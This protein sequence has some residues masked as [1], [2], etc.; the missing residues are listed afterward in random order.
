[1]AMR[2]QWCGPIRC[3]LRAGLDLASP[4]PT[5]GVVGFTAGDLRR[6][7]QEGVPDW[8]KGDKP[9]TTQV[10]DSVVPGV[11]LRTK[12]QKRPRKMAFDD[13]KDDEPVWL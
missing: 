2:G 11:G 5:S 10:I 13:I 9:W 1:M 4:A 7:Y 3:C 6:M 8:V 12:K